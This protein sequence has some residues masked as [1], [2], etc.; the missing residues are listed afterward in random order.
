MYLQKNDLQNLLAMHRR[1]VHTEKHLE[2][3]QRR[4]ARFVFNN[5][6]PRDSVPNMFTNLGWSPLTDRQKIH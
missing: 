1:H 5:Y 4:S 2:S 3:V 6:S